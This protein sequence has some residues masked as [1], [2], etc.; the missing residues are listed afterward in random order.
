MKLLE[1][2]IR[3]HKVI[4]R[5]KKSKKAANVPA[6]LNQLLAI[7]T[8]AARPST[9]SWEKSFILDEDSWDIGFVW[10]YSESVQSAPISDKSCL[11]KREEAPRCEVDGIA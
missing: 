2:Q 8:S 11:F 5:E 1:A 3:G 6:L 7:V 9:K 4:E 10:K